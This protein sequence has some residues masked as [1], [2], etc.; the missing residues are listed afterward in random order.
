MQCAHFADV[1]VAERRAL[2]LEIDLDR[3][4]DEVATRVA[5][6]LADRIA[7]Q[8]TSRWMAMEEAIACTRIPA[9]T[10]GKLVAAGPIPAHGGRRKLFHRDELDI[11]LGQLVSS[12]RAPDGV[13]ALPN[14]HRDVPCTVRPPTFSLQRRWGAAERRGAT[15]DE[16]AARRHALAPATW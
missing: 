8:A 10:F 12:L 2:R 6:R 1:L 11:A 14:H 16:L 4:A 3:L 15:S 13:F 9:G 5:A 7:P